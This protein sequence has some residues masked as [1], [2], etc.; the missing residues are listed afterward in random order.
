MCVELEAVTAKTVLKIWKSFAAATC[1]QTMA[2]PAH[3]SELAYLLYSF[4][5]SF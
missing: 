4:G 5:Y 1:A 2:A 3:E